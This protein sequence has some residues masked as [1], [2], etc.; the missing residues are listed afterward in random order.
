MGCELVIPPEI[1]TALIACYY[2]A[3]HHA[4]DE[5]RIFDDPIAQFLITSAEKE[6]IADF[7]I[8]RLNTLDPGLAASG[9]ARLVMLNGF[10]RSSPSPVEGISRARYAEDLLEEAISQGVRQYVLIGAGMDTFAFRRPDLNQNLQLFEVDREEA[11]RFKRQ[12]LAEAEIQEPG[13]LHFVTV[14]FSQESLDTALARSEYDPT[15]P[16]FF[17]W[18]GVT[19]FL[20][21]NTVLDTLRAIKR[22]AAKGS[23]VVFDYI[24]DDAFDPDKASKGIRELIASL[25]SRDPFSAGFDPDGLSRELIQTGFQVRENLGP[26]DIETRYFQERNDGFHAAEHAHFAWAVVE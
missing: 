26:T 5:P 6:Y 17:G 20:H 3:H 12:R 25:R 16:A 4:H 13:N 24:D 15:A 1:N 2:R 22:T 8:E 21:H 7:M 18:L 9:A 10:M 23:H 11:Q 19:P 14:D